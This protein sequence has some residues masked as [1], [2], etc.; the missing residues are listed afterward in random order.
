[1]ND[2]ARIISHFLATLFLFV[3]SG[4]ST[5][6][7]STSPSWENDCVGRLQISFPGEVDIAATLPRDL[8]KELSG[9]GGASNRFLDGQGA[10]W[11]SFEYMKITHPSTLDEKERIDSEVA[12]DRRRAKE[13]YEEKSKDTGEEWML[14]DLPKS[15]WVT[16]AWR[17]NDYYQGYFYVNST[18]VNWGVSVRSDDLNGME[19]VKNFYRVFSEGLRPRPTF[20]VP[21]DPGVCLPYLFVKDD[22]TPPRHI[23]MTYRLKDHPDITIWLE[24]ASAATVG[25][26]QDPEKFSAKYKAFFFWT[27]RYQ[28]RNGMRSLLPLEKNYLPTTFAGQKGVK[29]FIELTRRDGVTKDFGYLIAVRG[30]PEAKEDMPDL[31]FYVIQ[32]SLNARKRGIEPLGKKAFLGLAETIAASVKR[33]EVNH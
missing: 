1:M 2:W 13:Y 6:N 25:E 19:R 32:D 26:N 24:D 20:D 15:P 12:K 23:G 22:G 28:D 17:G 8:I 21:K 9:K 31:M 29:T 30:D 5:A 11:S 27:Q 18:I 7:G 14:T 3:A 4:S 16:V 10:S 33:R